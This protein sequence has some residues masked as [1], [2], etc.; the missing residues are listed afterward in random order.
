MAKMKFCLISL[1]IVGMVKVQSQS[2]DLQLKDKAIQKKLA[3]YDHYIQITN[4]DSI[5]SLYTP[6]GNLGDLA[7]GRDSIRKF[8]SKF[9]NIKVLYTHT[10]SE[11]IQ[12]INNNQAQQF[13]HYI[14]K[15]VLPKGDTIQVKGEIQIWWSQTKPGDWFI[16]KVKTIPEKN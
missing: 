1:L 7:I 6:H 12:W 16:E 4:P 8:L 13:G 10:E 3:L 9:K 15:A 2:L 11:S 14:Q 5:A